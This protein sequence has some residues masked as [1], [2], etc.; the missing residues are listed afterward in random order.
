MGALE[1]V[2]QDR[3]G[4]NTHSNEN[5]VV[6]AFGVAAVIFLRNNPDRLAWTLVNLSAN[7]AYVGLTNLVAATNGIYVPANGGAL[8]M[9]WQE[10]F[11]MTGWAWWGIT[12]A[13]ASNIFVIEVVGRV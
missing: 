8:T 2:L 4:I 9:N 10:D 1:K 5:P 7:P 13:G 12:P 3:F 11:Q 6:A